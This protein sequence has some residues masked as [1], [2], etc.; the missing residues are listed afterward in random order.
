MTGAG[1]GQQGANQPQPN[2]AQP[3][4]PGP[5][6]Q[7]TMHLAEIAS[8]TVENATKVAK[9]ASNRIDVDA[10][11]VG[12]LVKTLTQFVNVAVTGGLRLTEAALDQRPR[13][14]SDNMFVLADHMTSIA[15]R[16]LK[17]IAAVVDDAGPKVADNPLRN[18]TWVKAATKLS[19]IAMVSAVEAA[20]TLAIG[21]ADYADPKFVSKSF[22][23]GG[24]KLGKLAIKREL[25]RSGTDNVIPSERITF[26]PPTLS[27]GIREFRISVDETGLPSGVYIGLVELLD[28][29]SEKPL[30]DETSVAV[31]L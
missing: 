9:D 28:Q 10:F 12:D 15:Q 30:G 3:T 16:A 23:M 22:T 27:P 26:M 31:R 1:P 4:P 11:G 2:Q 24:D 18:S 13:R 17:Y 7:S 25:M 6:E 14:P 8:Q 21:P 20:E 29:T 5:A 19:D